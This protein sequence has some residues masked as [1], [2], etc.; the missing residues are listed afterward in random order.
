MTND[1]GRPGPAQVT[2]PASIREAIV[3]QARAEYPN[4]PAA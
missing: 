3:A 1:D 2:L 4:K